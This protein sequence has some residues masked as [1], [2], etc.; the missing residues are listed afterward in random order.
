MEYETFGI[1]L[2]WLSPPDGRTYAGVTRRFR[3]QDQNLSA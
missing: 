1:G 2:G 3:M